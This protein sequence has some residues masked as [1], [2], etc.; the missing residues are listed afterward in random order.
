LA[1][2]AAING[3]TDGTTCLMAIIQAGKLTVA[4]LGDSVGTLVRRDGS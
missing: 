1:T 3:E 2:H 4:S